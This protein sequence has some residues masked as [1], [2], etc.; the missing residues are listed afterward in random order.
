MILIVARVK[1]GLKKRK[2]KVFLLFLFCSALAWFI[3]NLSQSFVSD[4]RF[5]LEYI[6][7]P[8]DFLLAATPKKTIEV[9]L[10]AIGFQFMGFEIQKQK[11]QIDL[12]KLSTKDSKYYIL[13]KVYRK[14]IVNQLPKNMELIEME[15][16]TLF[17]DLIKL[18]S[19]EVTVLPR[20]VIEL[21][22][23]YMLEDSILFSPETVILKGPI[24]EVDT[25]TLIRTSPI[26]LTN[27]SAD[28]SKSISLLLPDGL[29]SS[30]VIP[31]AV[32][33]SGRVFRFSEKVL[34]VPVAMINVPDS[35][36]V[37][38]FPDQVKVLCVGKITALK[39]IKIED[40]KVVADYNQITPET[41]NRLSLLLDSFPT[42]LNKATLLTK[43]IEFI[44]R[45]Q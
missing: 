45:R 14:Q 11:V 23:N 10:R 44:L 2:V 28:F 26:N 31:A 7:I 8:D 22:T 33:V 30:K 35:V 20:S 9:R 40:L 42:N 1:A 21:A 34:S 25:I 32:T 38:M 19:K 27:L 16:D 15:S 12:A 41:E 4:T 43:E 17:I 18:V 29:A 24:N 37:R 3:N 6:Q 5:S 36:K 13:P 39:A